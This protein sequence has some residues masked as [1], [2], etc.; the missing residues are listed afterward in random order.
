MG[1]LDVFRAGKHVVFSLNDRQFLNR[2]D[3]HVAK[4]MANI[5]IR[6]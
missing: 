4:L 1:Y 6:Q 3:Q 2:D 5:V